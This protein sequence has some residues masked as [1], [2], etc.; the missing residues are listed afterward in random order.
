ML[1]LGSAQSSQ[2]RSKINSG[3]SMAD[4]G[5]KCHFTA[6]PSTLTLTPLSPKKGQVEA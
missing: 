3:S 5:G 4:E 1:P 2:G 6:E